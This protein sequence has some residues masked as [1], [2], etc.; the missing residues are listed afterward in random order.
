M[1]PETIYTPR[2]LNWIL[3]LIGMTMVWI[4][5]HHNLGTMAWAFVASLHVAWRQRATC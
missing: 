2:W 4:S 3:F 5:S 1:K